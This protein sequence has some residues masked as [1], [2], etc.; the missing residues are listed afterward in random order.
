MTLYLNI[1]CDWIKEDKI[2]EILSLC[3]TL[4]RQCYRRNY[5]WSRLKSKTT[6]AGKAAQN[7]ALE[8]VFVTNDD[9]SKG[10]PGITDYGHTMAKS[11]IFCGPNKY[12]GFEFWLQKIR[13]LAIVCP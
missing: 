7:K 3:R 12:L 13:D 11:L 5:K 9:E 1:F 2:V 10:L 6:G 4:V 8:D